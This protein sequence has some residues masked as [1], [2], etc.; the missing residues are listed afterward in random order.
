MELIKIENKT[1]LLA[2]ETAEKIVRF[3]TAMKRLKEQEDELKQAILAEM[4]AKNIIKLDTDE[5]VINYIASTDRETFD[6]KAFRSEHAD[7]YDQYVKLT[8]VKASIRV[9]V[10]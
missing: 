1:A 3:E 2:P 8:Q 9:K 4:E 10:K 6:S 5:L 7:L